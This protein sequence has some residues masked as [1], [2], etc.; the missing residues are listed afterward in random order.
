MLILLDNISEFRNVL[1]LPVCHWII[2]TLPLGTFLCT[3]KCFSCPFSHLLPTVLWGG[4]YH[5][6]NTS[7]W[8]IFGFP[9][10]SVL[11]IMAGKIRATDRGQL[12]SLDK[13]IGEKQKKHK[14][15][16]DNN[17]SLIYRRMKNGRVA[18]PCT[19]CNNLRKKACWP[20]HLESEPLPRGHSNEALDTQTA[21]LVSYWHIAVFSGPMEMLSQNCSSKESWIILQQPKPDFDVTAVSGP[22]PQGLCRNTVTCPYHSGI[23]PGP[24][25]GDCCILLLSLLLS[26]QV[27]FTP[28]C[29]PGWAV[30]IDSDFWGYVFR[31]S[32]CLPKRASTP[33]FSEALHGWLVSLPLIFFLPYSQKHCLKNLTTN[34]LVHTMALF[35]NLPWLSIICRCQP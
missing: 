35:V 22:G 24:S 30:A 20:K 12:M 29:A 9:L 2:R 13:E 8:Q 14:N 1:F 26:L 33:S 5:G 17:K 10:T 34:I 28:V 32:C 23:T 15:K 27:A 25:S 31:E 19:C 7:F 21:L 18:G 3:L 4:G 6:G 11:L 16:V